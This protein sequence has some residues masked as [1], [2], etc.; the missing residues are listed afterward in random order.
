LPWPSIFK[1]CQIY[2]PQHIIQQY[3]RHLQLYQSTK[4]PF[5]GISSRRQERWEINS[6]QF[7]LLTSEPCIEIYNRLRK[8]GSQQ[9]RQDEQ[10]RLP[11]ENPREYSNPIQHGQPAPPSSFMTVTRCLLRSATFLGV[12]TNLA[13]QVIW[14]KSQELFTI[15]TPS[16]TGRSRSCL[17]GRCTMR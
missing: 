11:G 16:F 8:L 2:V 3:S 10:P 7:H 6:L 14:A 12:E 1:L 9:S 17:R 13:K 15:T 4:K 5:I